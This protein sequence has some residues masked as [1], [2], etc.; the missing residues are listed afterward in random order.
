MVASEGFLLNV[1]G[2]KGPNPG[3][4]ESAIDTAAYGE[5]FWLDGS[6]QIDYTITTNSPTLIHFT[7]FSIG[8]GRLKI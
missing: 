8:R 7:T 1:S 6:V 2:L 3:D 5:K 4:P